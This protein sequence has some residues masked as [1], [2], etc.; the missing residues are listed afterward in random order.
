MHD[1]NSIVRETAGIAIMKNMTAEG[2]DD[3]FKS[4]EHQR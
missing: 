2:I 1:Q 4:K 3:A